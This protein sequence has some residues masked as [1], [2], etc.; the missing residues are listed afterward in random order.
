MFFMPGWLFHVDPAT[1]KIW[2]ISHVGCP[3]PQPCLGKVDHRAHVGNRSWVSHR[4]LLRLTIEINSNELPKVS[5][6]NQP[7]T[8]VRT[9]V[10]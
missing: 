6:K 1:A 5:R 4:V 10:R 3:K 9:F 8:C 7:T 2:N